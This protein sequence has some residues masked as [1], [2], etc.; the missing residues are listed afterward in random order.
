MAKKPF[1]Y[2]YR[3]DKQNRP[4]PGSN[5]KSRFI[6]NEKR[7]IRYIPQS[8]YCCNPDATPVDPNENKTIFN[9]TKY[10]YVRLDS[11]NNPVDLSLFSSTHPNWIQGYQQIFVYTCCQ[12]APT[13][14]FNVDFYITGNIVEGDVTMGTF[15]FLATPPLSQTPVVQGNNSYNIPAD[16][17]VVG[18]SMEGDNQSGEDLIARFYDSADNLLNETAVPQ[19]AFGPIGLTPVLSTLPTNY[20]KAIIDKVSLNYSLAY[21]GTTLNTDLTNGDFIPSISLSTDVPETSTPFVITTSGDTLAVPVATPGGNVGVDYSIT[22][23]TGSDVLMILTYNDGLTTTTL[24]NVNIPT[25]T[26]LTDFNTLPITE[27]VFG[28]TFQFE[29]IKS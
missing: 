23:N 14:P 28:R 19:N 25:G 9:T 1:Y 10:Y 16:T 4:I 2:Y 21:I 29:F 7:I 5:F 26:T 22:N 18:L 15:N 11:N 3:I 12:S 8:V 24:E 20:M 6:L 17:N 27:G 13:I